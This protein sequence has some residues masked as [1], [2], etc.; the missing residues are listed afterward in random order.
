[1]GIVSKA[2][3]I[4]T[5]NQPRLAMLIDCDNAQLSAMEKVIEEAN[6]FGKIT[7][8]RAYGDWSKDNLQKWRPA[9]ERL[10]IEPRQQYRQSGKNSTDIALVVEAMD[11]LH[12]ETL[13][14]F[15]LYSGDSD[16]TR[17]VTRL[18]EA[19][20]LV[21]GF[22]NEGQTADSLARAFDRYIYIENL[23]KTAKSDAAAQKP[24][25]T[26]NAAQRKRLAKLFNDIYAS[27][28]EED[29]Q[30]LLLSQ[31]GEELRKRNPAFDPRTYNQANL[32]ALIKA[33][34][35]PF[36]LEKSKTGD[37]QIVVGRG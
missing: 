5:A 20:A 37:P 7:V 36:K 29:N 33:M 34:G 12:S 11:F 28:A 14:G 30:R 13:E 26:I 17:L 1:M 4:Q 21:V 23:S 22:G 25:K 15:C 18:R 16:Y 6:K 35:A 32:S 19:G 10:M 2:Y 24:D 27:I 9:L 31:F 3:K 8:K